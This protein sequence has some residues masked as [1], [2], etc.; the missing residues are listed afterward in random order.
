[1]PPSGQMLFWLNY[2]PISSAGMAN[3]GDKAVLPGYEHQWQTLRRRCSTRS[4]W[5]LGARNAT[6]PPVRLPEGHRGVVH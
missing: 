3:V 4:R 1:M 2:T 6:E 5:L